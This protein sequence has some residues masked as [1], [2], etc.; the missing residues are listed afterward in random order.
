MQKLHVCCCS[1][2]CQ[3]GDGGTDRAHSSPVLSTVTLLQALLT[4]LSLTVAVVSCT[5]IPLLPEVLSSFLNYP[6]SRREVILWLDQ[7]A[8]LLRKL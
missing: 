3:G 5:L 4:N 8:P 6:L 2:H 1:V 7:D